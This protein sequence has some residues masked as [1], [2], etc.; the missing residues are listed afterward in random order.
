M[1][2]NCQLSCV[3]S[4]WCREWTRK[5]KR[6]QW[7]GK[8]FFYC[9]AIKKNKRVTTKYPH[10]KCVAFWIHIIF[11]NDLLN[12][13]H[14]IENQLLEPSSI[15]TRLHIKCSF[16]IFGFLPYRFRITITL[17][18]FQ[19]LKKNPLK[20]NILEKLKL[21]KASVSLIYKKQ[22]ISTPCKVT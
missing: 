20:Y 6:L 9:K 13:T 7:N 8:I 19:M 15:P 21:I 10:D 2:G 18:T 1:F 11:I 3:D 4:V 22:S 5:K 17:M 14:I 12:S 16:C